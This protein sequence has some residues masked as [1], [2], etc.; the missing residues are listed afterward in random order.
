MKPLRSSR[1]GFFIVR[2][3][4]RRIQYVSHSACAGDARSWNLGIDSQAWEFG[5]QWPSRCVPVWARASKCATSRP[6]KRHRI[7][8]TLRNSEDLLAEATCHSMRASV[9]A[10]IPHQWYAE[11]TL[12]IIHG[13]GANP[14]KIH[15]L[16]VAE[17]S[18]R[19]ISSVPHGLGR[20]GR[21]R[22]SRR[23]P[24]ELFVETRRCVP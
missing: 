20:P 10:W 16:E 11:R 14:T 17:R 18:G 22:F 7:I 24:G 4:W 3:D 5:C 1:E 15:G 21:R 6:D 23:N 13:R 8:D 12:R 2:P 9:E 19:F